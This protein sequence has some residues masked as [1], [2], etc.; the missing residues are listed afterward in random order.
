MSCSTP[1][2][3]SKNCRQSRSNTSRWKEHRD[4]CRQCHADLSTAV[5]KVVERRQ[6]LDVPQIRLLAHEHQ[7]EVIS[8]PHC[9]TL[10]R[11]RFPAEVSA[12]VQYGPNLQALAV[13][14]HQG[15]LLPTARTCETLAALCGCQISE[16]TVLQWE[17]LAAE[18]LA[19]TI[20][21]IAEMIAA[22]RL[23]H[24]DE[25][26]IRIYGMLHWLH[27]NG[28]PFLTH[29]AWHAARGR[30]AMEDIGIWP[31]FGGRGMHDRWASYDAY[32]CQHSI[33]GVRLLRDCLAVAQQE[34]QPW[35]MEMHDF[36]LALHD[37]CQ[38]WSLRHLSAVPAIERDE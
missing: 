12:S 27:V 15:Q 16:A 21:R 24:G 36:L 4:V 7:L 25:T 32:D 10:N 28:T 6:V 11:G 1:D 33:C 30:A 18:R 19:P 23:Q 37:A 9:H 26:G 20:E 17:E 2:A 29:L 31:R 3:A 38:E 13:Y 8:C 14:L 35:V 5:G 34:Y 22:S